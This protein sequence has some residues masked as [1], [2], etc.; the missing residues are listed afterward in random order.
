MLV[1]LKRRRWVVSCH[2]LIYRSD[3]TQSHKHRRPQG[4]NLEVDEG[5]EA[6]HILQQHQSPLQRRLHV[7][8]HVSL[9]QEPQA[10]LGDVVTVVDL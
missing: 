3:S 4:L 5:G 2:E 9:P 1:K 8:H 6:H 7:N 10:G